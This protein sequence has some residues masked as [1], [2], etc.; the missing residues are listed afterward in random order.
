MRG[1]CRG[2]RPAAS[3]LQH[4]HRTRRLRPV[5]G[6]A[7]Q[8]CHE[9]GNGRVACRSAAHHPPHTQDDGGCKEAEEE[10]DGGCGYGQRRGWRNAWRR[11]AVGTGAQRWAQAAG[12]RR[13]F[14][15]R[16]ERAG[17]WCAAAVLVCSRSRSSGCLLHVLQA[18]GLGGLS[19]NQEIAKLKR[20]SPEEA[21]AYIAKLTADMDDLEAQVRGPLR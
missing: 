14:C 4:S 1:Q 11:R 18:P 17:V 12:P 3:P 20:M 8:V 16:T 10:G 9:R 13:A 15:W 7:W 5:F 2:L 19:V 21:E 6:S